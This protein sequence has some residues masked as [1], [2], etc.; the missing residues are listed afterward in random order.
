MEESPAELPPAPDPL[1]VM[2]QQV[3]AAASDRDGAVELVV[4]ATAVPARNG[5]ELTLADRWKGLSH[6]RREQW[7]AQWWQ[8]LEA[9]GY[10][11]LTLLSEQGITLGRTA[12]VG[13]GMVLCDLASAET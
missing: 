11:E 13:Q 4:N 1:L 2:V 6:A 10:S 9:A 8:R 12:R 7:A 3:A 5:V